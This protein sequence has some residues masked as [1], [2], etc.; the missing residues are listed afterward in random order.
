MARFFM[1][2][3]NLL[4]G[5]AIIKGRDAEH[6]AVLRLKPGEEVVIC[7]CEGTD[8]KCRLVSSRPEE[9]ELE[10]IEAAPCVSEP[11]VAVTVFAGMPKGER[12]DVIVQKCTEGGA[13]QIVFFD[14]ARCVARPKEGSLEHKLKRWRSIAE[15]A[16][17]QSGRGIIPEIRFIGDYVEMLDAAIKLKARLFMYEEGER[18]VPLKDG[19]RAYEK[20][21]TA[22]IITGPEGGFSEAEAGLARGAGF[23][24]C[25]MGRRILRC[26]TAPVIALAAL[27]Y[28]T[29][30][31]A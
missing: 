4:K 6:I 14:C 18:R 21:D 8:Y 13:A 16:A 31:L 24:I 3:T 10:I 26:E 20:F 23:T 22:A 15:S 27:M 28:E 17:Q 5:T 19:I 1:A 9:A 7:D 11:S 30:N 25:S 2:G 12:S 29:D